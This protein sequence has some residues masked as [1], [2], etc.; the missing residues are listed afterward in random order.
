LANLVA[1][2]MKGDW[3]REDRGIDEEELRKMAAEYGYILLFR[4]KL[5]P[6][7]ARLIAVLPANGDVPA[8]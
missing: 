8:A 4:L 6:D 7:A 2:E 3:N 5:E 1:I